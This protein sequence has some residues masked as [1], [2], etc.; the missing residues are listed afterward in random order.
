MTTRTGIARLPFPLRLAGLTAVAALLLAGCAGRGPKAG[1]ATAGGQHFKTTQAAVDALLA[2]CRA[3]DEAKL[4][5]IFGEPAKPLVST[6]D[7]AADRERCQ[8]LVEAAGQSLRVDPKGPDTAQVVV[9]A[10]DWPMPIPLVKDAA[11]WHFDV[12]QGVQEIRRRRIGADELEAI[13]ACRLYVLAQHEYAAEAWG[14]RNTFAQRLVSSP[15][16]KDGLYWPSTG[17]RDAS[18]LGPFEVGADA[19][20]DPAFRGYRYRILQRQ[21]PAA[22]GGARSY[23]VNGKMTRGFALVAY[24]A[25]YGVTGIMTFIV[26]DDGRIYQRD[27]GDNT[28]QVAAAMTEY[29]PSPGW[30]RIDG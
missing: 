14:G 12:A 7:P 30:T 8:K 29:D 17:G 1:S 19:S 23:V 28:T 24:P 18:P 21:G 16:K 13:T 25:V 3:N 9:G 11:G 2:A 10:D 20:S 6:G 4:V 15:G 27:L 5:A 26:G 22:R